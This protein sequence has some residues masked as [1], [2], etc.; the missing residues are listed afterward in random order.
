MLHSEIENSLNLKLDF[1]KLKNIAKNSELVI[2]VI[3]QDIE[4][5]DILILAYAN[6]QAL[7]HTIATKKA[8]FWSTTRNALWIKGKTSGHHLEV[9]DIRVNCEQN[10]LLYIVRILG[11]GVCHVQD[12]KGKNLKS[13]YYR[14]IKNGQLEWITDAVL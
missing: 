4:S 7:D 5:K 14:R 8:T 2:P 3:V 9:V 6:Q 11:E 12:K 13:C 1:Q 10:S